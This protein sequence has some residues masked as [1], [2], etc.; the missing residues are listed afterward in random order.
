MYRTLLIA[1]LGLQQPVFE[2]V[3]IKTTSQRPVPIIL[4]AGGLDGDGCR[5]IDTN[6]LL[7]KT[8]VGLGRC[9][10]STIDLKFLMH[11]AY[12]LPE[13]PSEIDQIIVGGPSWVNGFKF[14]LDA[15][16]P[17]PEKTR[18][19]DINLMLQEVL[20]DRFQLKFHYEDHAAQGFALM[21]SGM[22]LKPSPTGSGER[23]RISIAPGTAA[24][25]GTRA[26]MPML[27]S[28]LASRLGK[29]V[30]DQTGIGGEFDFTLNATARHD[31]R[32]AFL[33]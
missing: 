11:R 25:T 23:P 19:H 15:V 4:L 17:A 14:A 32:R 16:A 27:A 21:V 13:P 31:A 8:P 9:H 10:F 26:T 29:P 5:G 20:R 28:F 6:V 22:K 2:A 12:E 33:L 24:I 30:V 1:L 18:I 7:Q 3:S